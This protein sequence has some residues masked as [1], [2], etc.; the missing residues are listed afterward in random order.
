MKY[1]N[2]TC[3]FCG[4]DNFYAVKSPSKRVGRYCEKCGAFNGWLPEKDVQ[5]FIVAGDYRVQHSSFYDE[6]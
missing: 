1:R 2:A 3:K 5:N 4:C 6:V